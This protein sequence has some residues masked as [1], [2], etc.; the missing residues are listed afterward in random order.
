MIRRKLSTH[1]YIQLLFLF[2]FS[3]GISAANENNIPNYSRAGY[4]DLDGS[5]RNT[6]NFNTGWRFVKQDVEGAEGVD[7]DDSSWQIVNL[8][9]GLESLPMEASGS[10]NYQGPAWYRKHFTFGKKFKNKKLYLY[11][12]AVMG[13]CEIYIDGNLIKRHFG[14]YLP[15]VVDISK[16]IKIDKEVVISVKADNSNDPTFPPGKPQDKL[17]FAYFGGIYRDV[18]LVETNKIHITDPNF[19]DKLAG[20]GVFV[21][22]DHLS[23]TNVDV[24][25]DTELINESTNRESLSIHLELKDQDNNIVARGS[26][27]FR[28]NESDTKSIRQTLR[29]KSPHLWSPDSPY[30][31]SLNITITNSKRDTLDGFKKRV[32][33]RK[34]DFVD[35][36]G[37]FLNGELFNDKLM[38]GNR[39]QDYAYL[40]NALPN[41]THYRDAKKLREAGMRI[42]RSAHYPQDPAFMDA[43]DE[44]GL[45]VIVA[46][47][48]WQ[49]WPK[50]STAVFENRVYSDIRQMVRQYR[51]RPSVIMW[52][53]ILN[54]THYPD[55]FALKT[56]EIV[57]E[58][59]P[60]QGAFTACDERAKGSKYFD[61]IYGTLSVTNETSKCVYTREWGDNVDDWSS[62]NSPSRTS[63]EWGEHAQLTQA[64]HYS[65]PLNYSY[66]NYDKLY[67]STSQFV[68][69]TLWHPFDHQ[70]G[71]HPDPFYGGI[72]DAIRQP[73]YSYYFFMSQRPSDIQLSNADSGPM[74]YIAHEMSPF[75]DPDVLVFSNCEKVRLIVCE[76]DTITLSAD[77]DKYKMPHPYFLFKDTYHFMS[78]KQLHR[79]RKFEKANIKAEG[80]IDGKVVVTHTRYPAKK[81]DKI[82]L[83]VDDN[84]I[85]LLADGNDVVPIIASICDKDGNI[86]RLNNRHII[87]TVEGEGSIVANELEGVNPIKVEWGTAPIL[88]RSTN[89]AGEIVVRAR[90]VNEGLNQPIG[91]E[92]R[93]KSKKDVS[94]SLYQEIPRKEQ[95]VEQNVK[96]TSNTELKQRIRKLQKRV[97]EL[98]LKEIEQQQEDFD[99]GK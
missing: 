47:P 11:F 76:E 60:Y 6:Y 45:F 84:Q 25:V 2:G 23:K 33:I 50:E 59:Y 62:H 19:V 16:Y 21:H 39:H 22:F 34:V 29:V 42:I 96:L 86:K 31:H 87:F 89:T 57:H 30:L 91:G 79:S 93:L 4:Y 81:V 68:G 48:G 3:L 65:F 61:V 38:G 54:E 46:T 80:I 44:L 95:H 51:N 35:G 28:I 69:G 13:K 10:V 78:I 85:D 40:G 75:S 49:F 24:V 52:E 36:K 73:K 7:Y 43:C 37:F 94:K 74:V 5:D 63:R 15:I 77:H 55:H 56:H 9:H 58:E 64:F 12:E 98:E 53:P 97:N 66:F 92:L 32:G 90:L 83:R 1:I 71:Y 99:T 18:W 41:T 67:R 72:L 70:R 27:S 82:V 14:G 20:G 26:K 88:V 8:P 17:D